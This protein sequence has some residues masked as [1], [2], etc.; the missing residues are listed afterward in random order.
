MKVLVLLEQEK[1]ETITKNANHALLTVHHASVT[2]TKDLSMKSAQDVTMVTSYSVCL[3]ALRN[4]QEVG[5]LI[6]HSAGVSNAHANVKNVLVIETNVLLAKE[7][8]IFLMENVSLIVK[9]N[10]SLNLKM[11]TNLTIITITLL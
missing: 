4:V 1:S 3:T 7:M 8:L 6:P 9:F 10:P 11:E 5:S 2:S